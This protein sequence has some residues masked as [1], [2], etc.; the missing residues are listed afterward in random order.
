MEMNTRTDPVW[1]IVPV[2]NMEKLLDKCVKSILKQTYSNW[3]LVLVDDG[4]KDCSGQMCDEYARQDSRIIVIHTTN[5]GPAV[6][7]LKGVLEV[8]DEGYCC[9]CDSDDELPENAIQLLYE[10][11]IKTGVDL[12]C[13]NMQRIC[14]G[15]RLPIRRKQECFH[16][17]GVY[18]KDELLRRWYICCFGGGG[19]F[20]VN[21]C[22]KLFRIQVLKSVMLNLDCQPIR[23]AEDLNVILQLFP[24]LNSLSIIDDIVYYYRMGGGTS[25][26]IPTFLEDNILMYH[27]KMEYADKCTADLDVR[28]LVAVELKNIIVSY[29][30]M[31]EKSKTY[32]NGSLLNEVKN[33]CAMEE[34]QEALTML[35]GDRSGIAGMNELLLAK[36]FDTVCER[37]RQN[38]YEERLKTAVKRLLFS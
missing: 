18:E 25:K 31:C 5:G 9:F 17:P 37:I 23:F 16:A 8:G 2:Y 22:G 19:A 20:P 29:R 34:V 3:K 30:K 7:R 4:S 6:A 14:R 28:R 12:V 26:F 32:P 24:E 10:E 27:A 15:I 35:D 38:I 36:D 13:G 33:V 11:A 21:M 1:I